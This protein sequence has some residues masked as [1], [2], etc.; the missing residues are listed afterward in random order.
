MFLG[1][2]A[3]LVCHVVWPALG[4]A[5][6][7]SLWQDECSACS[8]VLSCQLTAGNIANMQPRLKV[9]LAVMTAEEVWIWYIANYKQWLIWAALNVNNHLGLKGV[10]VTMIIW[11]DT[12][13][14]IL[15][16][17]SFVFA[18]GS[19]GWARFWLQRESLDR[20]RIHVA[21]LWIGCCYSK[22]R[23]LSC[24]ERKCRCHANSWG[25]RPHCCFD[26]RQPW[27]PSSSRTRSTHR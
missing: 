3:V 23:F 22:P 24:D 5:W 19:H 11:Y 15:C 4:S 9:T 21:D 1:L 26:Y 10:I 2:Y 18:K 16:C 12:A 20:L 17:S 8:K 6:D 13:R 27:K 14:S 25:Q 7:F